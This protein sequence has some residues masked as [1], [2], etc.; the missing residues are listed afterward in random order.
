MIELFFEWWTGFA[1][2]GFL[3]ITVRRD[4]MEIINE[5]GYFLTT[6]FWIVSAVFI[7]FLL[8]ISIP[9]TLL[10]YI[11]KDDSERDN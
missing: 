1:V 3:M 9:F 4:S 7:Y 5:M 11:N 8:P 10:H 2:L 6:P